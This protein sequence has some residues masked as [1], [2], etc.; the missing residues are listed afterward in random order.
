MP[1][2]G[3][4]CGGTRRRSDGPGAADLKPAANI[5]GHVSAASILHDRCGRP[6]V[7]GCNDVAATVCWHC[8]GELSRGMLVAKWMGASFTGQN[9]IRA[10]QSSHV[11]EACIWVM[12]RS[13]EV[14]GHPAEPG[15]SCGPNFRNFS[16]FLDGHGYVNA[17][18]GD[19]PTIR[20][21]LRGP[22]IG[23]WFAAIGESGQKHVVPYAPINLSSIGGR[24]Q[25]EEDVVSLPRDEDGW[26]VLDD[27]TALLTAGATK[28]SVS[29][30]D[31]NSHEWQLC[32]DT[33]I[34]FEA[35][36]ARLRNSHWFRLIVWL[37]QRDEDAVQARLVA[38][39]EAKDGKSKRGRARSDAQRDGAVDLGAARDVSRERGKPTE[40]LGSDQRPDPIE[41]TQVD[42]RARVVECA[43]A[44]SPTRGAEQVSLFGDLVAARDG[45]RAQRGMARSRRA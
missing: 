13:S 5:G 41:C 36:H 35:S 24:V 29:S 32:R 19:K 40:T 16:H 23:H 42:E 30:G 26:R 43:D 25:F 22:K 11:C 7:E 28:E 10:P 27:L 2:R 9:R 20:A 21:W 8:G 33:I 15:Q 1:A 44:Q 17:S 37:A 3:A 34:T 31:Y 14:P 38:Q 39:K 6:R 12:S 4:S 45:G 18:K